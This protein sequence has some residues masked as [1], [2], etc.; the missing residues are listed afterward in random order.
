MG[1]KS[2]AVTLAVMP[3]DHYEVLGVGPN[4]GHHEIRAA[5]RQL[6]REHHPDLRPGDPAS[7]EIARRI[8]AAWA[9]LGRPTS[10]S[11]YDRQRSAGRQTISP[12]PSPAVVRPQPPLQEAY[13]PAGADYRRAFHRASVKVATLVFVVGMLVLVAFSA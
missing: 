10:R 5:Y 7:E 4:A 12:V 2:A 6:M 11:A 13:S 3:S 1:A 9:V 8:T